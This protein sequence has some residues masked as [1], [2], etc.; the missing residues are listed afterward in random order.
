MKRSS[1]SCVRERRL[2]HVVGA[3]HVD[4]HRPHRALEHGVDAGDRG[5]VDDVRRAARELADRR[6]G[7]STSAW[8]SV[9][10]GCSA[11]GVPES[12]SRWRLSTATTSFSSTSRRA[13]VVPMKPAPPVMRIRLPSSTRRV[14]RR[15]LP[16]RYPEMR[17]RCVSFPRW[18]CSSSAAARGSASRQRVSPAA[19][20]PQDH[21]TGP[22]GADEGDARTCDA[23]LRPGRGRSLPRAATACRK[24]ANLEPNPFAADIP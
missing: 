2:E 20:R 8:W 17:M 4:A 3:D 1:V 5:A 23:A 21:G 19:H 24:L 16:L 10:F 18:Q 15:A 9:K 14:Y 12:A 7:S 6:P 13:S 22:T 11:S